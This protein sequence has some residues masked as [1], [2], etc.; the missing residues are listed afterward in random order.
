MTYNDEM[1]PLGFR[2][3]LGSKVWEMTISYNDENLPSLITE[4]STMPGTRFN[5]SIANTYKDGRMTSQ[6]ITTDKGTYT[7]EFSQWENDSYG[8]WTKRLVR[9]IYRKS[10]DD[11]PEESSYIQTRK[12]NY[13]NPS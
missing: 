6:V 4:S 11:S 3:A 7:L 9:Q 1:Y 2:M 13:Y 8:N 5:I 10:P 12:I